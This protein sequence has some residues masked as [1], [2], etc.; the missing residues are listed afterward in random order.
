VRKFDRK[1]KKKKKKTKEE[2]GIRPI[3]VDSFLSL[4][5]AQLFLRRKI[6]Q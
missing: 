5:P 3:L 6:R 1:K 2:E 4:V